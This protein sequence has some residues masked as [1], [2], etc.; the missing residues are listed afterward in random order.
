MLRE[1]GPVVLVPLAWGFALAAHAGAFDTKA[2]VIGHAVMLTIIVAFLGTSWTAMADGAL[3]YW[4]GVLLVGAG[5]TAAGLF[6]VG[7]GTRPLQSLAV[8][9]W[10]V[11]PGVAL[12]MTGQQVRTR[13]WA[14]HAGGALSLVGAAVYVA[15]LAGVGEGVVS[16][17]ALTLVGVGQTLGIVAAVLAE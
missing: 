6:G 8:V 12:V 15:W 3:R 10:M 16:Y 2:V 13:P 9:G 5:V 4:R 1:N 11:T 17:G 14:Y 7:T